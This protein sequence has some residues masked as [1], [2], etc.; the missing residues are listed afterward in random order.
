MHQVPPGGF[1][2]N[3][4]LNE[5]LQKPEPEPTDEMKQFKL[6]LGSIGIKLR[7]AEFN[8]FNGDYFL[9]EHCRELRRHVQLAKETKVEQLEK[10][11]DQMLSQI[12]SYEKERLNAYQ[13][14]ANKQ[15]FTT[16]LNDLKKML[17]DWNEKLNDH[18]QSLIK[19]TDSAR[20]VLSRLAVEQENLKS[21]I[22]D[23]QLL[24]LVKNQE[25]LSENLFGQLTFTS[26]DCIDFNSLNKIDMNAHFDQAKV[27]GDSKDDLTMIH[28]ELCDT[29]FLKNNFF[30]VFLL[31]R[32]LENSL[33]VFLFDENKT[34]VKSTTISASS[35]ESVYASSDRMC[36]NFSLNHKSYLAVMNERLEVLNQIEADKRVL[37]GANESF[38]FVYSKNKKQNPLYFY[39]WS[40]Q[41]TSTQ[42]QR[43]KPKEPF[44]YPNDIYRFEVK[45]GLFYSFEDHLLNIV[46]KN[47]GFVVKSIDLSRIFLF[48][49]DQD[50]RLMLIDEDH[51]IYMNLFGVLLKKIKLNNFPDIEYSYWS[52][53]YNNNLHIFDEE[54]YW[55]S[56]RKQI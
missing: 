54:N 43:T 29:L 34:L 56:V 2:L 15:E 18:Q 28:F 40:L 10:L 38:I 21:L 5:E 51:L 12:D 35:C 36:L 30:V 42:G 44:Y 17:N 19:E 4:A 32:H 3:E 22:F 9:K 1:E 6:L 45:N 47:R 16:K 39:D 23:G 48:H 55:L 53:D 8:L 25:E 14:N 41:L 37:I 7:Q 49:I 52:V 31:H 20:D 24:D 50:N 27:T 13:L 46:D 26:F 33:A 11:S